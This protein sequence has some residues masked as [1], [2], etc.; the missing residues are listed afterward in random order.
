[1][2]AIPRRVLPV[3]VFCLL[4][5]LTVA[6][7]ACAADEDE[8]DGEPEIEDEDTSEQ[9]GD[10]EEQEP[11]D[12]GEPSSDAGDGDHA[13]ADTIDD[14]VPQVSF[15]PTGP[16][17]ALVDAAEQED[18]RLTVYMSVSPEEM[19]PVFEA[20]M[21]AYPFVTDVDHTNLAAGES[22]TRILQETESNVP[23]A[24][25][26]ELAPSTAEGLVERNALMSLDGEELGLPPE[27]VT[28]EHRI[29]SS[30]TIHGAIV[31][32]NLVDESDYP[33]TWDDL[34]DDQWQGELAHWVVPSGLSSLGALWGEDRIREYSEGLANHDVHFID[35]TIGV[36]EAVSSGQFPM[37]VMTYHNF[38]TVQETGAPI[39]FIPLEPVVVVKLARFVPEGAG[40]PN[41]GKLFLAWSMTEEGQEIQEEATSRGMGYVQGGI[42]QELIGDR[43]VTGWQV[44]QVQEDRDM[45][46]VI[47]EALG[48]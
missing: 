33:S 11:D 9:D 3:A 46:T 43:P 16:S 36:I 48:R 18:G 42:A 38:V 35:S 2:L 5:F 17:D 23:T 14:L 15:T 21:E 10:D 27:L 30:D 8:A 39:E 31:N 26:G 29:A 12:A 34:L 45:R 24:D 25:L 40:N 44:E 32:T 20:F 37:G 4:L 22:A 7:T 47:E 6:L 1:M 13:D 41:T 19:R 28:D